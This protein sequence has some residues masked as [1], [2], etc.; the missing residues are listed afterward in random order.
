MAS[1]G[2]LRL[3]EICEMC[4]IAKYKRFPL[5]IKLDTDFEMVYSLVTYTYSRMLF[6]SGRKKSCDAIPKITE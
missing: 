4:N 1:I 2:L 6:N 5:G 3:F